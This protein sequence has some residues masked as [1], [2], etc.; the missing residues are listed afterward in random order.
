METKSTLAMAMGII[1]I[2]ADLYWIYT[3]YQDPTWLALGIII[4]IASLVWIGLDWS[5][6]RQARPAAVV[7]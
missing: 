4:L 5:L 2:I 3:S 1:I 6:S 7:K